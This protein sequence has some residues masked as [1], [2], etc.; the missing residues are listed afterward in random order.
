MEY[1]PGLNLALRPKVGNSVFTSGTVVASAMRISRRQVCSRRYINVQSATFFLWRFSQF[2]W[3]I[4]DVVD[5][6]TTATPF[7]SI[8]E[9]IPLSLPFNS[10]DAP[11][12]FEQLAS[13]R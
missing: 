3:I 13:R 7:L 8:A 5:S 9:R 6:A 11:N 12:H 2:Y 10:H 4:K 1:M